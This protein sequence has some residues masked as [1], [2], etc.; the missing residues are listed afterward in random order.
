MIAVTLALARQRRLAFFKYVLRF[1][2][3]KVSRD[4]TEVATD[5]LRQL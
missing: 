5:L 1:D 3:I 4:V 2:F